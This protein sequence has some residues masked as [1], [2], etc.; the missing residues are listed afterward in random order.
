MAGF[1]Q[2]KSALPFRIPTSGRR[3]RSEAWLTGERTHLAPLSSPSKC[4]PPNLTAAS[5]SPLRRYLRR[6]PKI[7]ASAE[8]Q[9]QC[10]RGW[11]HQKI[12]HFQKLRLHA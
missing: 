1:P 6:A 8:D 4:P 2:R 3:K 9:P 11:R 12:W 7:P 5:R 10:E